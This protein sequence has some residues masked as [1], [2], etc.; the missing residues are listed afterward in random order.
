MALLLSID[1]SADRTIIKCKKPDGEYTYQKA[2]CAEN[3]EAVTS[4]TAPVETRKT[5]I[6]LV[7]EQSYGG[8][9]FLDSEVNGIP[10]KFVVDTGATLVSLPL[11]LAESADIT[12]KKQIL[13]E[14]ANGASLACTG[15]IKKLKFGS[16]TLKEVDVAI[17]PNLSSPLL[18]MNILEKFK[19]TQQ[20]NTMRIADLD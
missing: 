13:M 12:C 5:N 18:G 20:G 14:T 11:S 1:A 2:P 15:I 9:Y 7:L 8:H 10:V 4:W 6:P 19:I 3:T 17:V 16:F